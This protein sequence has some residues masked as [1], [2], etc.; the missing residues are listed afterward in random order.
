MLSSCAH[1]LCVAGTAVV[2]CLAATP[3]R[4]QG[5]VGEY[6][7]EMVVTSPPW[8]GV[9]LLVLE[10]QH[11]AMHDLAHNE[12][13]RGVGI[14][15]PAYWYNSA[16]LELREVRQQKGVMEHRWIPAL[17]TVIELGRAVEL[18]NRARIELR[19]VAGTWSRRYQDRVTVARSIDLLGGAAMPYTYYELTYDTRFGVLNRRE[20]AA[21]IRIP[22]GRGTT[23]DSF[24]MRQTDTRRDFDVLV[25]AGMILRVAL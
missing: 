18:R 15:S 8:R 20:V 16:S 13:Q 9:R 3:L 23:V 10:E 19:D 4:A 11:L 17:N 25:A 22:V 21:G 1:R 6:R 12:H 14:T 24:L 5:A 7:P 2:M